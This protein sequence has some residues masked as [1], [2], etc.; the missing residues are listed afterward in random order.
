LATEGSAAPTHSRTSDWLAHSAI[1][2]L[3]QTSVVTGCKP[4]MSPGVDAL[5]SDRSGLVPRF[6][7]APLAR[8]KWWFEHVTPS[9]YFIPTVFGTIPTV[10]PFRVRTAPHCVYSIIQY[11]R[12]DFPKLAHPTITIAHIDCTSQNAPAAL[13]LYL[14]FAFQSAVLHFAC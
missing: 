8:R 10:K 6:L 7:R 13:L 2:T 11:P 14:P 1:R 9:T 12:T 3:V 5:L 4:S